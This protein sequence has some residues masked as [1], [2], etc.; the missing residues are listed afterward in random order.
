MTR[1]NAGP[2]VIARVGAVFAF[3]SPCRCRFVLDTRPT[4]LIP[5]RSNS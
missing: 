1:Q 2:N 3:K 5:L 4:R